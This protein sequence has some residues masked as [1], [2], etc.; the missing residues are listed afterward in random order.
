MKRNANGSEFISCRHC[1]KI[2][3]RR[4]QTRHDR[5]THGSDEV[6]RKAALL[7]AAAPELLAACEAV[8]LSLPFESAERRQVIA[9]MGKAR[10]H[11]FQAASTK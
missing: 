5:Q 11:E 6:R 7:A 2:I 10:G 9:A 4:G 8:W 3:T 1:G